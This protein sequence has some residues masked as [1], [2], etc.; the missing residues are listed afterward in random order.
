MLKSIVYRVIFIG[1]LTI[2]TFVM[3]EVLLRIYNSFAHSHIFYDGS[4]NRYRGKP[5]AELYGFKLNSGGFSDT[6]FTANPGDYRIVGLGDSFAFGIVPHQYTYLTK[7]EEK[8]SSRLGSI[9]LFNMGISQTNPSEYY[10]ILTNEGADLK[11]DMVLLSFFIG[12]DFDV[13]RRPWYRHSR[14]L[15]AL[16]YIGTVA[17]KVRDFTGHEPYCDTC[18]TFNRADYLT[19]EKGRYESWQEQMPA[20]GQTKDGNF[21]KTIATLVRTR[22]YCQSKNAKFI[23][24]II[25]DDIQVDP[26]LQSE[27]ISAFYAESG[28]LPYDV[29]IPTKRL[30]EQ[31]RTNKI[32]YIDMLDAFKTGSTTARLYKPSDSHWN[33]NGNEFAAKL[34][35]DSLVGLIP[36]KVKPIAQAV[37]ER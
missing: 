15:T 28:R 37:S 25:P 11:P 6:E 20:A 24:A 21:D 3:G 23:V 4:Y 33:I 8:L 36:R 35:A 5:Y 13:P 18:T 9:S 10:S 26:T 22:D 1:I 31:L 12:N 27:M 14:M 7:L 32:Q 29:N 19:I 16:N 30:T 17:W 2:V 34:L